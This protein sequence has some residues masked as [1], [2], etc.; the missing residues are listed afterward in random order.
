MSDA[1]DLV[2]SWLA[3]AT[4]SGES[5]A[6]ALRELNAE[7][8]TRYRQNRLYE[9]MHGKPIP[10]PV[11]HYMLSCC[12]EWAI[13]QEHGEPPPDDRMGRLVARLCPPVKR[14]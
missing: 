12:I 8:G 11:Q 5:K 4:G 10:E 6:E 3:V 7:L 2:H 13:R 14:G 1:L 9:W